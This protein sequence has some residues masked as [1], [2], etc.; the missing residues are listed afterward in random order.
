M[1]IDCL[2]I[3]YITYIWSILKGLW[4]FCQSIM[5]LFH[6]WL[7][8]K[9]LYFTFDEH[10]KHQI[11]YVRMLISLLVVQLLSIDVPNVTKLEQCQE[12][13][14]VCC[15]HLSEVAEVANPQVAKVANQIPRGIAPQEWIMTCPLMQLALVLMGGSRIPEYRRMLMPG[16]YLGG[17]QI[18]GDVKG[19][20]SQNVRD[21]SVG[22]VPLPTTQPYNFDKNQLVLK[23]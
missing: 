11:L 8:V 16:L 14:N 20:W 9:A 1:S 12:Q 15:V 19:T 2:L 10:P 17:T 21:V 22:A 5:I 13:R 4:D 6:S 23:F 3:L 18:E 7:W